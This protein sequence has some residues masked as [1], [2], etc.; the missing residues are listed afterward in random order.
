MST[1]RTKKLVI[2]PE[3]LRA[4]LLFVGPGFVFQHS[5]AATQLFAAPVSKASTPSSGLLRHEAF[6][7]YT[8]KHLDKTFIHIKQM[9]L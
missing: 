1:Y 7:Y 5:H 2:G 6:M 4:L 8:H 3:R 9:D